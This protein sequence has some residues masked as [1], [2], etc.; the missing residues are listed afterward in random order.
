MDMNQGVPSFNHCTSRQCNWRNMHEVENSDHFHNLISQKVI[1]GYTK[2][3]EE[4][5][6]G[7]KTMKKSLQKI[8]DLFLENNDDSTVSCNGRLQM[9]VELA[10]STLQSQR[11]ILSVLGAVWTKRRWL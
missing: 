9:D 2:A 11:W 10:M 4:V 7:Y 8:C 5:L 3:I 6:P 1:S